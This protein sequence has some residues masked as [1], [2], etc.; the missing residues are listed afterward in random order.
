MGFVV[1]G[2]LL[3]SPAGGAN[4]YSGCT[5]VDLGF[6]VYLECASFAPN[7]PSIQRF[8]IMPDA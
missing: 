1:L 3:G 2:Q 7:L 4:R 5:V 8:S 6:Q